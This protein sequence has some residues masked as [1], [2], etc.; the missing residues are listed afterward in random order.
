[1]IA[2]YILALSVGRYRLVALLI[3]PIAFANTLAAS[4]FK[5]VRNRSSTAFQVFDGVCF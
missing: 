2:V 3:L 4:Q 1:M 5:N